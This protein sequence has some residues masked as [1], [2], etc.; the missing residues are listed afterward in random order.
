[1]PR[2]LVVDSP[3]GADREVDAPDGGDLVLIAEEARLPIPFS[4]RSAGCA[5]CHLEVLEGESLLEAPEE[6]EAELLDLIGA[7]KGTRL[8]CQ[9]RLKPGGGIVRLRPL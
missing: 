5:T 3:V 7:P 2:V 8:G 1:V 9:L 4:C 6:A